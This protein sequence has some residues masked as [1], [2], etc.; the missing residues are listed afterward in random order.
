MNKHFVIDANGKRHT[1]NSERTYTNAVLYRESKE[2]D[3]ARVQEKWPH[4]D[5]NFWYHMAY[6][7]GTSKWL[8]RKPW[9]TD[10]AKYKARCKE[11]VERAA[12]ALRGCQT[13]DELFQLVKSEGM[14]IIENKDYSKWTVK[15]WHTTRKLAEKAALSLNKPQVIILP[16]GIVL[17][18]Y[19]ET[20]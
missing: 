13:P 5:A 15:S 18:S 9:E 16:V 1:R 10:D 6:I 7:N 3:L 2:Q 19:G 4:F 17:A 14:F 20:R 11:D 8:E 12:Y